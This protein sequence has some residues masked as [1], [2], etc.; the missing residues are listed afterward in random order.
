MIAWLRVHSAPFAAVLAILFAGQM[1]DIFV[2]TDEARERAHDHSGGVAG[3]T[4]SAGP[5]QHAVPDHGPEEESAIP[6]CVCH[7]VFA[8]TD[9]PPTMPTATLLP[10]TPTAAALSSPYSVEPDPLE[11]VPLA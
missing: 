2:C 5:A 1:T 6:D 10:S 8:K 7:V 11:H 3:L 9:V 4:V